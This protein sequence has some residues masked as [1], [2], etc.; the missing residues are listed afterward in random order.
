MS[1]VG[2]GA[3][4][5]LRKWRNRQRDGVTIK[6]SLGGKGGGILAE[7]LEGDREAVA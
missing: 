7:G 4:S 5:L 3:G 2:V 6:V 1:S